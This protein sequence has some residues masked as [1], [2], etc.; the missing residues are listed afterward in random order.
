MCRI[1]T[2][3]LLRNYYLKSVRIWSFSGPFFP[4]FRL[5]TER[6]SHLSVLNPNVGKYGRWKLRKVTVTFHAMNN[7]LFLLIMLMLEFIDSYLMK[8]ENKNTKRGLIDVGQA[9]IYSLKVN[10][11]NTTTL[12]EISSQSN[13]VSIIYYEW[14]IWSVN[15]LVEI[16]YLLEWAPGALI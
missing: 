2:I 11:G 8:D 4:T 12:N 6:N 1:F 15:L 13:C 5:N 16:P 10:N 14:S 3:N 9:G 7:G